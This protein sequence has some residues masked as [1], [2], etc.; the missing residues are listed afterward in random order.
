MLI[1][2]GATKNYINCRLQ[3]R[4]D[5]QVHPEIGFEQLMVT[6]VLEVHAQGY[7]HFVLYSGSYGR[8]I[9]PK[10]FRIY[11]KS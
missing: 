2:S 6:I 10:I 3:I 5:L 4:L 9:F 7:V 8:P 1:D 11:S